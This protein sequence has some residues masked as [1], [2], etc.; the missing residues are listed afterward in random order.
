[1]ET[2]TGR[3]QKAVVFVDVVGRTD[4]E[5]GAVLAI[6]RV[7]RLMKYFP[8]DRKFVGYLSLEQHTREPKILV[9]RAALVDP[10]AAAAIEGPI[11]EALLKPHRKKR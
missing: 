10:I 8:A 1:M 4:V 11:A 2:S 7:S 6:D 5:P 3:E 9:S